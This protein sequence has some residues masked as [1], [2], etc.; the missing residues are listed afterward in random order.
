MNEMALDFLGTTA[1]T[2]TATIPIPST[3]P[4]TTVFATDHSRHL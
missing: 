3:E 1:D 4:K 2:K